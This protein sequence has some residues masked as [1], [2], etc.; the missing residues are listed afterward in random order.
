MNKIFVTGGAG[1]IGS[2]FVRLFAQEG[3]V[4]V[5]NVDKLTDAGHSP[6]LSDFEGLANYRLEQLDL[7]SPGERLSELMHAFQPDTVIH[8]AAES[9]VDRSIDAPGAF[10]Q[11]NIVGTYNLLQ[12]SLDYWKRLPEA[13]DAPS[14]IHAVGASLRDRQSQLATTVATPEQDPSSQANHQPSQESFRYLHVSTDEVFGSLGPDHEP[15]DEGSNYRPRSPYAASKAASDH[16]VMAWYHTYG[17]PAMVTNSSNNYG[18]CQ[19]PE[20]LI[21]LVILNG[22]LN[23]PIPVY[24]TGHNIRNWMHVHDH[25][26]AI[27]ELV[28]HGRVGESYLIAG[29]RELRNLDLIQQL[30]AVLDEELPAGGGKKYAERITFV[31]DRPGHDYR[32]SIDSSK[33]RRET[34]WSPSV[35]FESGLRETVRWY[36]SNREWLAEQARRCSL[37]DCG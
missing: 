10:I 13:D 32:Y 22:L 17:L 6:Y 29:D 21:P 18:P 23:K 27:A 8:F 3:A 15:F 11:T 34:A 4:Q 37:P 2:N 16:L 30:C 31:P 26:R 25:C 36:L 28:K 9:H 19:L 24:G 35:G 12:A 20:K 14:P 7:A 1:F 5:L 33:I